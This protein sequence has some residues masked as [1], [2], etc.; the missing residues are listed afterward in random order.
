MAFIFLILVF[1]IDHYCAGG[2]LISSACPFFIDFKCIL[3]EN[4][5]FNRSKTSYFDKKQVAGKEAELQIMITLFSFCT[6]NL[7]SL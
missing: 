4:L 7:Y 5:I 1:F 6:R 3:E 2:Y